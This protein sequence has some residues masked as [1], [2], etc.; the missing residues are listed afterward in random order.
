MSQ[1]VSAAV[2][3]YIAGR[4]R[5]KW[6]GTHTHEVFFRDTAHGLVTWS[7]AAVL[8]V[9]VLTTLPPPWS[10]AAFAPQ[11]VRHRP[12]CRV[13]RREAPGRRGRGRPLG[14]N[15]LR[16][17]QAVPAAL[18]IRRRGAVGRRDHGG[19]CG[20][21]GAGPAAWIRAAIRASRR[22]SSPSTVLSSG[23]RKRTAPIWRSSCSA[24]RHLRAGGAKRVNVSYADIEDAENQGQDG[25][26]KARKAAAEAVDLPALSMLVGAFVASISA[27]LGGRL[28]DEHFRDA[29]LRFSDRLMD[30]HTARR[31]HTLGII[32][33][34]AAS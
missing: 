21:R 11:A 8:V 33:H 14:R 16:H 24:N 30:V 18:R 1:W 31:R 19:G 9:L 28:R 7:V 3:G 6:V 29:S 5:T 25:R 27:A 10:A 17:R 22:C 12:D 20:Q 4:L 26:G 15:D 32:F 23:S 13:R 34:D 2:G